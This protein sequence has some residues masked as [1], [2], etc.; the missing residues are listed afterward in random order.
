M[1][2]QEIDWQKAVRRG[3][4]TVPEA[5]R[6]VGT[7]PP[8]LQSWI[9]GNRGASAA[10]I[11]QRQLPRVGGR[12]VLGFLDLIEAKF[13][14]HF[15]QWFSPQTIRKVSVKL[16]DLHDVD[17]PFAMDKRFRTDGRTIF[18]EF[19]E[20]EEERRIL[21]LMNDNFEME[22]VIDQSLFDGIF[23]IRDI[24]RHWFPDAGTGRVVI[25]PT[26]CFGHPIIKDHRVPTRQLFEAYLA[27]GGIQQAAEEFEVDCDAVVQ[28]VRFEQKLDLR[29]LH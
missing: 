22:Q 14:R 10:P 8:K 29:A 3:I 13:I 25:D 18:M 1:T 20:T 27:E 9:E 11:I 2:L 5:A 28:A 23:Y 21:N 16:R 7:A 26:I 12:A 4:Y 6:L 19:A 15:T 17:H 24:A